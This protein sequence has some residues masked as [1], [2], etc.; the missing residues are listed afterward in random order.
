MENN[1]RE[2]IL[3]LVNLRQVTG[4]DVKSMTNIIRDNFDPTFSVCSH[5]VAQIKFG[6]QQLLNW[7]NNLQIEEP[8]QQP[9]EPQVEVGCSKCKKKQQNKK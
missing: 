6:R 5:C 7:Y 9:P 1:L 8:I 3:R 4:Y 2:E